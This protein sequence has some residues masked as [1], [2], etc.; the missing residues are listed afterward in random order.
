MFCIN[1]GRELSDE[2]ISCPNCGHPIKNKTK[3][4]STV[5]YTNAS[6]KKRLTAL[7]LCIFL[8][9]FGAHRFYAGKIGTGIIQLFTFGGFFVWALIDFCFICGGAFKD[10]DG[11]EIVIWV[12]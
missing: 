12:D 4:T 2:A 11:K 9:E 10:S 8:G 6:P 1:C 3:P 7:L 5:D